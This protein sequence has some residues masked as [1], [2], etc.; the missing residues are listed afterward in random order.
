LIR[1]GIAGVTGYTGLEL[2]KLLLRHKEVRIEYLGSRREPQPMLSEV[3]PSLTGVMDRRCEPIAVAGLG[4]RVDV[5]FSCLPHGHAMGY[6]AA[7]VA[8][9]VTVIDLSA[10]YRLDDPAVFESVYGTKHTDPGRLGTTPFGLPE[11]FREGLKDADLVANPGCYPTGALLAMAP[12]IRAGLADSSTVIVD[13]KT[14]VSGAGRKPSE[15]AH[16]PECNE[17]L[18][19]YAVGTHRHAPEIALYARRLGMA[20][21]H[22][23]FTPQLAPMNRGILSTVYLVLPPGATEADVRDA[24]DK[25]YSD[26]PFVRVRKPGEFPSTKDTLHTN[27]CDI[28]ISV[29]HP[30]CLVVSA[31]DNL[32]KGASGQAVQNMNAVFGL[33]ETTGLLP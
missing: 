12:V 9:G 16:F 6:V 20:E 28:A 3:F 4:D 31:I 13:A 2:V 7:A 33:D 32:V 30:T 1:V 25:A 17:A 19:P 14:G 15:R 27:F 11:L 22:I 8:E 29:Q 10:D 18:T 23:V 21:P 5:V 26:E 24:F